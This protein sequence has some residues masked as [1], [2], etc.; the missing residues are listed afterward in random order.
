MQPYPLMGWNV[1]AAWWLHVIAIKWS[2]ICWV[3]RQP[4]LHSCACDEVS[5]WLNTFH[6]HY[7]SP[8]IHPAT[9]SHVCMWP[10]CQ[11]GMHVGHHLEGRIQQRNS[12]SLPPLHA[13]VGMHGWVD[14][15]PSGGMDPVEELSLPPSLLLLSSLLPFPSMSEGQWLKGLMWTGQG[16]KVGAS[17]AFLTGP[18]CYSLPPSLPLSRLGQWCKWKTASLS[19]TPVRC[20]S[21]LRN[22]KLSEVDRKMAW[23]MV[24]RYTLK[25]C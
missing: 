1:R 15:T 4:S 11:W 22:L 2:A 7:H 20:F 12:P 10:A 19:S 3:F 18:G 24:S 21:P 25:L 14:G 9:T 23:C 13:N 8:S 17:S 16:R 5:L 6:Y